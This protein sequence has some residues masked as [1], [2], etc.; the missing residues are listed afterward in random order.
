MIIR[1]CLRTEIEQAARSVEPAGSVRA[2]ILEDR[3]TPRKSEFRVRLFPAGPNPDARRTFSPGTGRRKNAVSWQAHRDFFRELFTLR[4]K[5]EVKT[6]HATYRGQLDFEQSHG[7]TGWH[8][9]GP[10]CCP[11]PYRETGE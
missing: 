10:G 2:E 4:P 6:C 9:V 1:H 7:S 8:N 5:A 3:G 11:V